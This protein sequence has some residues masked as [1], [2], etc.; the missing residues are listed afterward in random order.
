MSS[1]TVK[2]TGSQSDGGEFKQFEGRW[3]A[4]DY[5]MYDDVRA[6][7]KRVVGITNNRSLNIALFDHNSAGTFEGDVKSGTFMVL[8]GKQVIDR[9]KISKILKS[10]ENMVASSRK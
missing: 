2:V 7:I 3:T 1:I 5:N 9:N 10:I 6:E 8:N 4:P